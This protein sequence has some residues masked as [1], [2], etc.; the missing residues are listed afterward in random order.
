MKA[1]VLI[2]TF[3]FVLLL[4]FFVS[5]SNSTICIDKTAPTA[6]GNLH[7]A[8][9]PYDADGNITLTWIAATDEPSCSGVDHYN[10]YR[11]IDNSN[12]TKIGE[13]PSSSLSFSDSNLTQGKT[14]YYWVTAVD[15]VAVNPHE[16]PH[17]SASTT[18]GTASGGG[19]T[20]GGGGGSVGGG[21]GG[22]SCTPDWQCT[23]WTDCSADLTQT[24]T[25]TDAN[26]CGTNLNKPEESRSCVLGNNSNE[27]TGTGSNETTSSSSSN[28]SGTTN[29][30]TNTFNN[31]SSNTS[32]PNALTG[33]FIGLFGNG[34][35][36][37]VGLWVVL[38]IIL[39]GLA[40]WY[41]F[42][43]KRRKKKTT[44]RR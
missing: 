34:A 40:A 2:S 7:I 4:S 16:G 37:K 21:S 1:T 41:F 32:R 31:T 14:Y 12:F 30:E 8:D 20:T 42:I 11:S 26:S 22:A 25:C 44:R 28:T 27:T 10:I 3:I 33:A 18:I 13:T 19:G 43:A 6:P 35:N 24:R 38:I 15:K 5:A 36:P 23:G 39:L 9:S 29:N 17:A